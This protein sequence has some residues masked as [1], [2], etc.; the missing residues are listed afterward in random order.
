MFKTATPVPAVTTETVIMT[1]TQATP[2]PA[3][4]SETV[5]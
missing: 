3:A 4:T 5:I 2:I 1:R